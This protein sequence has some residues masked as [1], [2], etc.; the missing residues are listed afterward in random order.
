MRG[1]GPVQAR[2]ALDIPLARRGEADVGDR[3]SL[4]QF[5]GGTKKWGR[6]VLDKGP[7]RHYI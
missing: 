5:F 1:A 6:G 7:G 2:Q 4:G 3:L